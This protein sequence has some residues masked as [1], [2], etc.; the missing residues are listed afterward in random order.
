MSFNLYSIFVELQNYVLSMKKSAKLPVVLFS[1][2]MLLFILINGGLFSPLR[3]Q[4]VD[5]DGSG[6][7]AYL[8][9]LLVHHTVDFAP[10]LIIEKQHKS[11]DYVGHNYH[12]Q[13][14][15]LINKFPVGAAVLMAPFY[16]LAHVISNIFELPLDGFNIV[17]Q[18]A[19][20]VAA[21]FWLSIGLWFLIQ[22]LRLH[23]FGKQRALWITITGLMATNLFFYGFVNPSFSHVYSFF[24]VTAFFYYVSLLFKSAQQQYTN[25]NLCWSAFFFGLVLLIRPANALT[26]LAIPFLAGGFYSF[27]KKLNALFSFTRIG[28]AIFF[29][30][31][32]LSPQLV[33]NLLQTGQIF[34]DGY[35]NE[36]FLFTHP[37]LFNFLFSYQ[38]GWFVYT[39]FMLLLIPGVVLFYRRSK[40]QF[41]A[42]LFFL[43]VLVYVF[44]SWWNWFYGDSFGMRPMV[45]YYGLF[46]LI[47]AGATLRIK[48]VKLRRLVYVFIA[49]TVFLNL[50]QS[51]Q[52]SVGI[53]H[54]DSMNKQAYWHVFLK[55]DPSYRGAIAGGDEYFYG[56]LSETPLVSTKNTIDQLPVSWSL[57]E[58]SVVYSADAN[59][60]VIEQNEAYIYSPGFVF[61]IPENF[62]VDSTVYI[63]FNLKYKELSPNAAL[64]A[65]IVMDITDESQEHVFYKAFR[66]KR[67]PDEVQNI[68]RDATMGFK[69]PPIIPAFSQVKFYIWNRDKQHYLLD[70]LEIQIF[71]F[72]SD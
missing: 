42:L 30:F 62:T 33:I 38:K 27:W 55:S 72:G 7:Y 69:L 37:H 58:K 1:G 14:D 52:Y 65:L 34:V 63:Q 26:V 64:H 59:S 45:E 60:L 57:N 28:M 46:M 68:W 17:Y 2:L 19:V 21:I 5:G 23:R 54:P 36:G 50:F 70:D 29:F 4:F 49:F 39:P 44:S 40:A 67:L 13:G 71:R 10:V 9:A 31:L 56:E 3:T 24:A 48:R 51:Y 61:N 22:L 43:V 8:P 47:I 66:F 16:V 41:Y 15:L 32:A 35:Q 53:L 20:G 11:A 25:A 6:H 12:K 18:W